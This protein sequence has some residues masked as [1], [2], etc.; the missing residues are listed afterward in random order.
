VLITRSTITMFNSQLLLIACLSLVL[1]NIDQVVSEKQMTLELGICVDRTVWEKYREKHGHRADWHLKTD[2]KKVVRGAE[3]YTNLPSISDKGGFKLR[4]RDEQLIILK[5]YQQNSVATKIANM[6]AKDKTASNS[7]DLLKYRKLCQG[8][9]FGKLEE[10]GLPKETND[11]TVVLTQS[12]N[13]VIS[14][15]AQVGGVCTLNRPICH[16]MRHQFICNYSP[17]NIINMTWNMGHGYDMAR[18]LTHEIGHSLGSGHN[19]DISHGNRCSPNK[20]Y[21]MNPSV[22]SPVANTWSSCAR[23]AISK[24]MTNPVGRVPKVENCFYD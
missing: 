14:G 6:A 7:K 12:H 23:D 9:L 10:M 22:M 2:V 11:L 4:L 17:E 13:G 1:G 24:E 8:E 21:F 15:L 18:L 20:R 5:S 16:R 19:G 3:K